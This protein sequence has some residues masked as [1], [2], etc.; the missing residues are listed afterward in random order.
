MFVLLASPEPVAPFA[1]QIHIPWVESGGQVASADEV[2]SVRRFVEYRFGAGNATPEPMFV[3]VSQSDE[4]A[5]HLV[6]L[7]LQFRYSSVLC[8][9]LA[10][11]CVLPL[12]SAFLAPR[13]P[14][15]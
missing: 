12:V 15:M 10:F 8:H 13:L 7:R 9:A 3:R 6:Q 1:L 11:L 14:R 2:T 4:L 5:E